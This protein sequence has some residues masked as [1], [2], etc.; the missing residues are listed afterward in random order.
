MLII[1][2]MQVSE[3]GPDLDYFLS[4]HMETHSEIFSETCACVMKDNENRIF[5]LLL[6]FFYFHQRKKYNHITC[7]TWVGIY[8]SNFFLSFLFSCKMATKLKLQRYYYIATEYQ[9]S[10]NC[11]LQWGDNFLLLVNPYR[12]SHSHKAVL[13]IGAQPSELSVDRVSW[14]CDKWLL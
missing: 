5:I 1:A 9:I 10:K 2:K 4:W 3:K 8:L 13:Y 6:F 7:C 12:V 11:T 14:L